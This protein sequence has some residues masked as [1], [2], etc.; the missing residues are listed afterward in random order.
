MGAES[1]YFTIKGEAKR[2]EIQ[3]AFE[4]QQEENRLYN[5]SR[6]GYSGDFQTVDKVDFRLH[7]TFE[8]EREAIEYCLKHAEKW[9]SVVAVRF[10][11][12]KLYDKRDI[13]KRAIESF[14]ELQASK[15]SLEREALSKL[16]VKKGLVKC[17]KC[18]SHLKA[19]LLRSENCPVCGGSLRLASYE[20]RLQKLAERMNKANDKIK[21]MS[22]IVRIDTLVAG[23]GAC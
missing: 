21:K 8:S 7:E 16:T 5:G 10:K 19:N 1:I 22:K 17:S 20:K 3:D 15:N 23:W 4:R 14:R 12:R 13:L 2:Q 6:D 9:S 11:V 18:T